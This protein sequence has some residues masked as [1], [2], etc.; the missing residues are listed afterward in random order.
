MPGTPL[1]SAAVLI[2]LHPGW[3]NFSSPITANSETR[4]CYGERVVG[5]PGLSPMFSGILK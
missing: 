1:S 4:A 3:T 5:D 2:E